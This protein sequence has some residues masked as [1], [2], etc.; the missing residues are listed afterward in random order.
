MSSETKTRQILHSCLVCASSRFRVIHTDKKLQGSSN[1]MADSGDQL[2]QS[3]D[4]KDQKEGTEDSKEAGY[5]LRNMF[6]DV[7][8][9]TESS[10]GVVPIVGKRRKSLTIFGLGRRGSDPVGLKMASLP[11]GRVLGGDRR[12][13]GRKFS[14]QEPVVLEEP[15]PTGLETAAAMDAVPYSVPLEGITEVGSLSRPGREPS[16]RLQTQSSVSA[17]AQETPVPSSLAISSSLPSQRTFKSPT[18]ET[19]REGNKVGDVYSPGPQQTST[20]IAPGFGAASGLPSSSAAPQCPTPSSEGFLPSGTLPS[21]YSVS[22]PDTDPGIGKSLASITL[23]SSPSSPFPV[24]TPSPGSLRTPPSRAVLAQSLTPPLLDSRITTESVK[25]PSSSPALKHS[26]QMSSVLS[27]S[28]QSPTTSLSLGR[29]PS[30]SLARTPSPALTL[31]AAATAVSPSQTPSAALSS[32]SSQTSPRGTSPRVG[33]RSGSL[34]SVASQPDKLPGVSTGDT[35]HSVSLASPSARPGDEG[36]SSRATSP[37]QSLSLSLPPEGRV[38][39]VSIVK[40]SPDSKREF[41]V[42]TMLEEEEPSE[43][44]KTKDKETKTLETSDLDSAKV[45]VSPSVSKRGDSSVS[46]SIETLAQDKQLST[47]RVVPSVSQGM[48][49]IVELKDVKEV[50][51]DEN[52]EEDGRDDGKQ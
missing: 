49:D 46:V 38:S 37:G 34:A 11:G 23:G 15:L 30:P 35:V 50:K 9:P 7:K 41:T 14:Q 26:P 21:P 42:V 51:Q 33:G 22:T 31:N 10:N 44:A 52:Q 5:N 1:P 29:V 20:P 43:S 13:T 47:V 6:K 25:T 4:S 2:N 45:D 28:N 18:P 27:R 40:A 19:E 36:P 17:A 16:D 8:Q 12:E 3:Q 32:E 48:D 39:S 24:K